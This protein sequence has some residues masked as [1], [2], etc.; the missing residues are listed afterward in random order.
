MKYPIVMRKFSD[1]YISKIT[2]RVSFNKY[3]IRL[4]T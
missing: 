4:Q 3:D 2:H 1:K